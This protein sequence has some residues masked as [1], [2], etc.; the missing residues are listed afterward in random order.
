MLKNLSAAARRTSYA[1]PQGWDHKENNNNEALKDDEP[2]YGIADAIQHVGTRPRWGSRLRLQPPRSATDQQRRAGRQHRSV[3]VRQP[4]QAR[5]GDG[6][7]LFLA[8]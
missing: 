6:N 5:H 1:A 8:I 7:R 4:R 3:R 2:V